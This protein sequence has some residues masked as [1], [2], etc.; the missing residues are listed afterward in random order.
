MHYCKIYLSSSCIYKCYDVRPAV[1]Y[2]Y[3]LC[4]SL[5]AQPKGTI[6][7]EAEGSREEEQPNAEEKRRKHHDSL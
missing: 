2:K 4:F 5:W 7:A 1:Q 3:F 6:P